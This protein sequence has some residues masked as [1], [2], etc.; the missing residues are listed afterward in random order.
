MSAP[1][2]Q[3]I[4]RFLPYAGAFSLLLGIISVVRTAVRDLESNVVGRIDALQTRKEKSFEAM[5]ERLD[6]RVDHL[7]QLAE[8]GDEHIENH[9]SF[10]T[11][12]LYHRQEERLDR[13]EAQLEK[14]SQRI[15]AME[16]ST[17]RVL[18]QAASIGQ[19]MS[20]IRYSY[21]ML[22]HTMYPH[23]D[24]LRSQQAANKSNGRTDPTA[25]DSEG[26]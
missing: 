18:A 13:I 12:T 10:K 2:P 15:D 5:R 16:R 9:I 25:A 24:F 23:L 26:I 3:G 20:E 21:Q 14:V 19:S 22:L 17:D 11:N 7:K 4:T 6:E 8:K 1:G